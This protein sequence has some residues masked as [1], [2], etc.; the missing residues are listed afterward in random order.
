M[1]AYLDEM[2]AYLDEISTVLGNIWPYKANKTKEISKMATFPLKELEILALAQSIINGINTNPAIFVATP[3]SS[4][5]LQIRKDTVQTDISSITLAE[6]AVSALHETKDTDIGLLIA[7]MKTILAWALAITHG[8]NAKMELLGYGAHKTPT[9]T[10][11]PGQPQTLVT[12]AQGEGSCTLAWGRPLTGDEVT[13]YKVQRRERPAGDWALLEISHETECNLSAQTRGK[14]Y[15][16]RVIANNKVGDG[17]P[18]N[19]VMAVL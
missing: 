5:A 6:A 9:A 14:E 11:P 1:S 4:A 13:V 17:P 7:D 15:E 18:S 16:F 2:S 10:I 12:K 19:T 3:I 8:D